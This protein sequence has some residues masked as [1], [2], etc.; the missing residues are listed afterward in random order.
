MYSEG[1]FIIIIVPYCISAA[2]F[3]EETENQ[4]EHTLRLSAV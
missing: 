2:S 1:F 3:L 4:L